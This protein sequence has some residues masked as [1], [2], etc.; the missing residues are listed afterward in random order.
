MIFS[1]IFTPSHQSPKPEKR[2][3]AIESLSPEKAQEKTILHELAFNDENPNVSLAALEKLNSFVLWLKMSQIAKQ[4]RVKKTAELKVNSALLN[5]GALSL[6]P[7]E[8]FSFLTETASPELV[9]QLLPKM[10]ERD[11]SL[12][13]DDVLAQALIDKVN[14]PSFTHY[15]FLEGASASLQTQIISAQSHVSDLQKLAKKVSDA[16]LLSKINARIDAIKEAEQRP[17][18]LKKQLTLTLS[19][20]QALLDKADVEVVEE[21]RRELE[22]ELSGL[23]TQI[24]LLTQDERA[25]YEEKR[26]RIGEQV[27]RYLGRIRPGWEEK[28]RAAQLDNTKALCE[29]QLTHA[30]KQVSWLYDSRLCEATLADVATVNESVRGVE[31]TLEQLARLGKDT[32]NE[33]RIREILKAV[34]QLND[35]LERF[36]MQQH[37][38]QK[39][40][41]KLQTLE[42]IVAKM[43]KPSGG[44]ANSVLTNAGITEA[45]PSNEAQLD[46]DE[47]VDNLQA[48]FHEARDDYKAIS[49]EIDAIPDV[50]SARYKAVL[51]RANAKERANKVRENEQVKNARK[52]ISVIDNLIA[53]GKFRVAIA[54]FQKLEESYNALSSA[55]KKHVEKRFEKTSEEVTH[56]E[57]WQSYLAAPRKPALV[58][59]A[60]ALASTIPDDIKARSEAIKYLRKQ[61]LSLTT[62]SDNN[63]TDNGDD[64]LQQQFDQALE[65]AFEPCRAHYA[66]LDEQRLQAQEK[67]Q[68]IIASAKSLDTEMPEAEL[69]KVFDRIAKQWHAAGQVERDTYEQLKHEWKAVSSPIQN[70][71][72]VWQNDNQAQKRALVLQAQQLANEEDI[73]AGADQAQ[74]LQKQWKQIGHAGKREESKLWSEFKAA[75]DRVFERVKAQRKNQNNALN[76]QVD[77]LL[78]HIE[79]IDIES[80]EVDFS[81]SVSKLRAQLSELPK[82]QR[83]KVE[84]KLELI[85]SKREALEKSA[86]SQAQIDKAQALI[87]LLKLSLGEGSDDEQMLAER[88]GKRWSNLFQQSDGHIRLQHDRQWLTV[89]LEVA[90]HMPSPDADASIRSSVQLQM[91]TAKL[92]L[93]E[94]ATASEIL[95]D[96]LSYD[97]LGVKD[98]IFTQR[99]IAIIDA[100][101][102]VVA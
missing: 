3:Q 20:F 42:G 41:I 101:P 29:Q 38:G 32:S 26:S 16:D 65:K 57:G 2:M 45:S 72:R 47:S 94:S 50:L 53:Q 75:N 34:N 49:R 8:K 73:A 7:E 4:S 69:V 14:K 52:Q 100:H 68:S 79:S 90:S 6:S 11:A 19:K 74:A 31:A 17:I 84:R 43:T 48:A 25:E 46:T 63:A 92:E 97:V 33:K 71:I 83:N 88:L 80:H 93:G 9:V 66:K 67:R 91:M 77:S 81:E 60:N 64:S 51:N 82:P 28:Q 35:K 24:N 27:E 22:S 30:T 86:Q 13:S 102:E 1:R 37:Y 55:A 58:E 12:L 76:A 54:K 96:W 85:E 21:K 44:E 62:A 36:S 10:K 95:A 89:A 98:K 61:W 15:V 78:T 56:L 23:F 59:E 70:K 39:L 99:V 40:L 5:E 87:S 18:E